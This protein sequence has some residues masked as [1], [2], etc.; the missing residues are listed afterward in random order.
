MAAK[1][2]TKKTVQKAKPKVQN[3]KFTPPKGYTVMELTDDAMAQPHD[4]YTEPSIEGK[5]LSVKDVPKGGK[6]KKDTRI[7]LIETDYGTRGVWLAKQLEGLFD[8]PPIGKRVYIQLTGTTP[9][10]GKN[11]MKNFSIAIK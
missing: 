2:A 6:I 3:I 4:F 11:D 8:D 1:K 10:D 5:V 7:M 9:L